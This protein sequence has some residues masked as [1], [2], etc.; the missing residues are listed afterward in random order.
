M[1]RLIF[2]NIGWMEHYQ[3][4]NGDSIVGGGSF[5]AENRYGHEMF[6]FLPW[7]GRM[8]GYVQAPS[9]HIDKLG[10]HPSAQSVSGILAVW[11]A[12]YPYRGGTYIVGWYENA[13]VYRNLQEPTFIP[14]RKLNEYITPSI[15]AVGEDIGKYAYYFT[16]TNEDDSQILP[17]SER[18]FQIPRGGPGDMGRANVWFADHP[19]K[20][21]FRQ[22]V[23]DYIRGKTMHSNLLRR[24][25]GRTG[26][27]LA[28]KA[29]REW[30]AHNPQ[31]LG[32]QGVERIP[33]KAEYGFISGDIADVVFE[34]SGNRFA[35]I[36]VETTNPEPG[37]YQALKYRTLL[38]AEKG[39]PVDSEAITALLVA[40][41]I[42]Q[43][44][45]KFCDKYGIKYF[46]KRI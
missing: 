26:E 43:N 35:T 42:P 18:T 1:Y 34:M 2:L 19:N 45:R 12:R 38:C 15:R 39:M 28:H 33:G 30:C 40:W 8:Y 5:V 23:I 13:T 14:N 46:E 36:E 27:G 32:L 20:A 16:S 4:L 17:V 21:G 6:N 29:L 10:A 41:Q 3:G 25:Y 9:I 31:E 24:K 22:R 11:V 37:A 44:V 7:G